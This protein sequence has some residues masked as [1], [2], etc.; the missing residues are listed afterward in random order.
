MRR[1]VSRGGPDPDSLA[2][3]LARPLDR[4]R[5]LHPTPR[6]GTVAVDVDDPTEFEQT[7]HG[8][9]SP[10]VRVQLAR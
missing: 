2:P 6:I 4:L 7:A 10:E 5:E 3:S 1:E 9:G 8:F